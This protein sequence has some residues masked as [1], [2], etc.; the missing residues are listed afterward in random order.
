MKKILLV[1]SLVL[2]FSLVGCS[3][4]NEFKNVSTADVEKAILE[5][6]LLVENP[7]SADVME[8]DY[9][10]DIQDSIEE[11]FI[12][13]AAMIVALEDVVFIKAID[14]E[15]AAKVLSTVE[16]YKQDMVMRGFADG[17]GK[18][19]NATRAANTIVEQR[20]ICLLNI[21]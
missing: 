18:P 8:F 16:S 12:S 3:S 9:F 1:L 4:T 20:K 17:Y 15:N 21:C 19:E 2:T 10:N 11:G 7:M 14:E 5:S 6:E 13:R